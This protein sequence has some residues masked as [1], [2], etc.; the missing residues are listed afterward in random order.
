MDFAKLEHKLPIAMGS[1][2]GVRADNS[3]YVD[4]T[5]YVQIIAQRPEPQ[6][7]ARPRR[8]GKSTLISTLNELF[9][10]G[11]SP[12]DG[13]DSYFK[14]VDGKIWCEIVVAAPNSAK[15]KIWSIK[16]TDKNHL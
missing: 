14:H 8:F 7:L 16:I 11:T 3:V 4:K 12:Y 6:I 1:F 2:P 10:H 5:D 15:L 13:H 9:L